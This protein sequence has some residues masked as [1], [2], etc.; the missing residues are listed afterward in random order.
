MK[1]VL[2][3]LVIYITCFAMLAYAFVAV[4]PNAALANYDPDADYDGTGNL[5][6][7]GDCSLNSDWDMTFDTKNGAEGSKRIDLTQKNILYI[8]N[9]FSGN[10]SDLRF[11]QNYVRIEPGKKYKLSFLIKSSKAI[12]FP[13]DKELLIMLWWN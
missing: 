4:S 6:R 5:F 11:S 13:K 7:N 8:V 12:E 10:R 1:K 9:K 3:K 2:K